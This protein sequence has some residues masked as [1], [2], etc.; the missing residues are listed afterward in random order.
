MKTRSALAP[1][2]SFTLLF[3]ALPPQAVVHAASIAAPRLGAGPSINTPLNPGAAAGAAANL[4]GGLLSGSSLITGAKL[5]VSAAPELGQALPQAFAPAFDAPLPSASASPL[6]P[7]G[8]LQAANP[9][10][11]KPADAQTPVSAQDQAE[12]ISLQAA[13]DEA[14]D[15]GSEGGKARAGRAFDGAD[16]VRPDAPAPVAGRFASLV[17]RLLPTFT[18]KAAAAAAKVETRFSPDQYGGPRHEARSLLGNMGYGLKWALNLTGIAAV[19]DLTLR[20]VLNALPW[21]LHVPSSILEGTGRVEL[22]TKFGPNAIAEALA[23]DPVSFLLL[24]VTQATVM[25]EVTFRVLQFG[26]VFL[27][28]A[29]VRPV[30]AALSRGLEQLPALPIRTA[31]QWGLSK[32]GKVSS[33]A[34][35]IAAAVSS[36]S[37]MVAHFGAWGIAPATMAV[38][39]ALGTGLAHVAYRS[40]SLSAPVVAHLVYN[41][42]G[43]G[44]ALLAFHFMLPQAA[45]LYALGLGLAGGAV[46]WYNFRAH[47]KDK[48]AA[49]LEAKAELKTSWLAKGAKLMILP[50]LLTLALGAWSPKAELPVV[51][52]SPAS[53]TFVQDAVG[54]GKQALGPVV[55]PQVAPPAQPKAPAL[56]LEDMVRRSKP[57]VVMIRNEHGLG[58]GFIITKE[59]V[60]VTNA[61]V[62]NPVP[63]GGE[64]VVRFANGQEVPGKVIAVNAGKDIAL[65]QLPP[66]LNGW[67]TVPAGDSDAMLEGQSVVAMGYPLGL[68]FTVT[69][70]IVSGKGGTRGNLFV[71]HLQHDAAVNPG[72]SGGPLFNERGEVIGMNTAIATQGGGFDGISF[73]VPSADIRKAVAQYQATGNINSS[74]IGVIVDRGA[75]DAPERGVLIEQVRPGSPAALAG[76]KAGDLVIAAAGHVLPDDAQASLQLLAQL[77][78]RS[79]PGSKVELSVVR[80]NNEGVSS[81]ELTVTLGDQ[82][83]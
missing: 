23:T 60:L 71:T 79:V 81:L 8:V 68:P 11:S 29:A 7:Q 65:V 12:A 46:L 83:P 32:L 20:P 72:N 47:S 51:Y 24:G 16:K 22:L 34:Y 69:S 52:K 67:P 44:G 13:S 10:G 56:S 33:R 59:G 64:M 37:F 38:H 35:L 3:S 48:R 54:K 1:F 53:W 50:L 78:A 74:W 25:E 17:Q 41:L 57:A 42:L 27:T 14:K 15:Q 61:H 66:A 19:L 76:L 6:P 26:L 80:A 77:L 4:Q 63:V 36:A 49:L 21:Q 58:S 39:L 75:A 40:R 2:L 43:L 28:A 70:G 5:G 45:A 18:K 82:K 31:L 62:V 73:S 55:A 30:T 9:T